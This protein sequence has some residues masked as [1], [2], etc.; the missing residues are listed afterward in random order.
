MVE[1]FPN[2]LELD[3]GA[4]QGDRARI[5][6]EGSDRSAGQRT[7]GRGIVFAISDFDDGERRFLHG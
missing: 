5:A 3:K 2:G 7:D 1:A 6:D 4:L